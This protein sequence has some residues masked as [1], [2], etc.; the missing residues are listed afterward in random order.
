MRVLV[1]RSRLNLF[2][3]EFLSLSLSPS[4]L[5]LSFFHFFFFFFCLPSSSSSCDDERTVVRRLKNIEFEEADETTVLETA[6]VIVGGKEALNVFIFAKFGCFFFF[7][8]RE[9]FLSKTIF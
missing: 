7:L 8:R 9:D 4:F 3:S 1:S 5:F 2:A 6:V